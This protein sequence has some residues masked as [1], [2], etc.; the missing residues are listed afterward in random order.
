M[1]I[2]RTAAL[3]DTGRRRFN[4]EDSYVSQPP[5]FAIA[6]GVGGAQAGEVAS[7]LAAA[8]LAE[9]EPGSHGE[10][11]LVALIAE[12]NRRIYERSLEDPAAAGMGTTVTALLVDESAG[13]IVL[14]HVGDSRAYVF[15]GGKLAQLTDD[16]SLV[17][18][19]V[20]SGRLSPE[21]AEQHPHRSV[22]TRVV[23]TESTVD[24]D[25]E[26]IQPAAG[27]VFIICSDGLTDMLPDA[28]VSAAIAD[29]QGDP[30]R[31]AEALVGAANEAG[32]ID[33]ITVLVFEIEEGDPAAAAAMVAEPDET[34]AESVEIVTQEAPVRR[35]G[36]GSGGR[37]LALAAIVVALAAGALLIWWS[38]GK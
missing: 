24:V 32:G 2:G 20:R 14:G 21:D 36:A 30:G 4:N 25:V 8:A 33:N 34:T 23:G 35:H 10:D 13:T 17:G 31:I 5:L 11:V 28:L 3:S 9:L 27:D 15:R 12:A 19:L 29:A 26:T 6:D 1:R 37:A 18:E 38:L 7:R 16:H 22:I